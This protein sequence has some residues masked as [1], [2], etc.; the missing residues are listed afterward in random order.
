MLLNV[1]SFT[2][3][4][5]EEAEYQQWQAAVEAYLELGWNFHELIQQTKVLVERLYDSRPYD[6]YDHG[7]TEQGELTLWITRSYTSGCTI[8]KV[9]QPNAWR[10]RR[11][12]GEGNIEA[13]THLVDTPTYQPWFTYLVNILSG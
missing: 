8:W 1:R 6:L 5:K 9:V 13:L 4:V 7:D 12:L 10:V 3:R 2:D 11:R